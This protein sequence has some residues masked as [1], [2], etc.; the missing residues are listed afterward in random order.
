M[1][2]DLLCFSLFA[3]GRDGEYSETA[4]LFPRLCIR[5]LM[6]LKS[7]KSE[8]GGRGAGNDLRDMWAA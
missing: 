1:V 8:G 4:Y 5:S 3:N 2:G 6:K 7:A